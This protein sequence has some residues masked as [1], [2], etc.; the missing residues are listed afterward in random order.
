[1]QDAAKLLKA[2]GTGSI[3]K[4]YQ[5]KQNI[6]IQGDAADSIF[7]VQNGLVRLTQ[8]IEDGDERVL[9]ILGSGEFFGL[10]CLARQEF[11]STTVTAMTDTTVTRLAR[12]L[13]TKSIHND[14]EFTR[15]LIEYLVA[16]STQVEDELNNQRI[17]PAQFRLART[18]VVLANFG[19]GD[20]QSRVIPGISQQDLA[21]IIGTTRSRVSFF[22]NRFRANGLISYGETT[23]PH[24]IEV[25]RALVEKVAAHAA[26]LN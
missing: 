24:T 3:V 14:E 11:R 18:L 6:Y 7:Y 20:D 22:L 9:S 13:V 5:K 17:Y 26:H 19:Q 12:E 16:H 1:M 23:D 15:E 21:D 10:G 4:Q 2:P 8:T 25:N